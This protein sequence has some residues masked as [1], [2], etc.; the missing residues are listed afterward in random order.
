[1][2]IVTP[3]EVRTPKAVMMDAMMFFD[4]LA[5]DYH[6]MKEFEKAGKCMVSAVQVAEKV[7]PYIHARLLAVESQNTEQPSPFVVRVPAVIADSAA[8]QAA[9]GAGAVDLEPAALAHPAL[10]ND[11]T[12]VSGP[13]NGIPLPEDGQLPPKPGPLIPK[14]PELRPLNFM[15]NGNATVAP[16]GSAEWLESIKKVG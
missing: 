4:R 15:P 2:T 13:A 7:A 1:M 10:Q 6:A 12:V 11:P 16:A 3:A 14:P 8:W 5:R 9:T